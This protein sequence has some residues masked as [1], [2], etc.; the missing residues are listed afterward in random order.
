[1]NYKIKIFV[2]DEA[3]YVSCTERWWI[4][5]IPLSTDYYYYNR[6]TDKLTKEPNP[7]AMDSADANKAYYKLEDRLVAN[8]QKKVNAKKKTLIEKSI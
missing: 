3:Y 8:K 2:K 7:V 5:P 1:M 6:F 4:F